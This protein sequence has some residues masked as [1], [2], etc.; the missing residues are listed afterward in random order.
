LIGLALAVAVAGGCR[1]SRRDEAPSQS[2]SAPAAQTESAGVRQPA[3]PVARPQ[4]AQR[5]LAAN[6]ARVRITA[7]WKDAREFIASP[8]ARADPAQRQ[9][10]LDA[11]AEGGR[12]VDSLLFTRAINQSNGDLLRL[13][14]GLLASAVLNQAA[15]D[16]GTGAG[17]EAVPTAASPAIARLTDQMPQLEKLIASP[18]LDP[19]VVA[20]VLPLL[21]QD[22]ATAERELASLPESERAAAQPTIDAAKA[23]MANLQG[24]MPR[25]PRFLNRGASG[26]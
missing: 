9:R 24:Q 25:G 13:G 26:Y 3:V 21:A 15:P 16:R 17:Q 6:A 10:V 14:T 19:T 12:D 2:A 11:L 4:V 18:N 22:I 8:E 7:A 1:C 20:G 5:L 23:A